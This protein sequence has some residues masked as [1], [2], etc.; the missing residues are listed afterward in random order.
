M[1][2]LRK[3]SI[4]L[5]NIFI[6]ILA[7]NLK[8]SSIFDK[9]L[10][11]KNNGPINLKLESFREDTNN[12]NLTVSDYKIINEPKLEGLFE[13]NVSIEKTN[14]KFLLKNI[15]VKLYNGP[16]YEW[17]NLKIEKCPHNPLEGLEY[18]FYL[19]SYFKK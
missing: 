5:I 16:L 9:S 1:I 4:L 15:L 11:T 17:F 3:Y 14:K 18:R 7:N 19:Y 12:I 13:F 2:C 8:A 10:D 6:F